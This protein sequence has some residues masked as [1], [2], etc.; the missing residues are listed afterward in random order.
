MRYLQKRD[1]LRPKNS[2]Y[3]NIWADRATHFIKIR[4]ET[5]LYLVEFSLYLLSN[6]VPLNIFSIKILFK[7]KSKEKT[8]YVHFSNIFI[9]NVTEDCRQSLKLRPYWNNNTFFRNILISTI[10]YFGLIYKDTFYFLLI[11]LFLKVIFA[12]NYFIHWLI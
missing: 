8:K 7:E 4:I 1:T 2:I 11:I 6:S 9:W 3:K 12:K 5:I 10:F